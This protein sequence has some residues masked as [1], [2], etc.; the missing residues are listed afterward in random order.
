MKHIVE[1]IRLLYQKEM[2]D[3]AQAEK[4]RKSNMV[5]DENGSHRKSTKNSSKSTEE[6]T[7]KEDD[8]FQK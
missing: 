1:T 6:S 4:T 5:M 7:A 8:D 3:A 2:F